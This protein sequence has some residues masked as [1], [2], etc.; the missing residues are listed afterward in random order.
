MHFHPALTGAEAKQ[1]EVLERGLTAAP[2]VGMVEAE[3]AASA[4]VSVLDYL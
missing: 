2:E 4:A 1:K 3:P